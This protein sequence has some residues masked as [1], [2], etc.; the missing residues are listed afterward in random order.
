MSNIYI[1]ERDYNKLNQ[2]IRGAAYTS[3]RRNCRSAARAW[4]A[5]PGYRIYSIGFRLALRPGKKG[6]L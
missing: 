5:Q 3:E 6:E 4:V 1:D 2:R